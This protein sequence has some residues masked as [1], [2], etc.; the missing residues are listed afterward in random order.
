MTKENEK[1][2]RT[3]E[4]KEKEDTSS[5]HAARAREE[6]F[7]DKLYAA[8]L[9]AIETAG[10]E[11]KPPHPRQVISMAATGKG[12]IVSGEYGVGKTAL[13]SLAARAF[14]GGVFKVRLA[15]PDDLD[16][17]TRSWQEYCLVNPYAQNAWL[18][19][20]GAENPVSDYGVRLERAGDFIVTWHELHRTGTR[21]VVTTNLTTAE[22][23]A[24]YGG[25]VLSRLKDLCVPLR[26]NGGDKRKW[27]TP[28]RQS[29]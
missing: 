29:T 9:S 14:G 2:E 11:H 10:K 25:R 5:A 3:K 7:S 23:D 16:R 20:L 18:D 27:T 21:L 26:L 22:L 4:S 13:A 6:L 28:I 24:R 19:D 17:L 15:I 8:A 12:L 1:R